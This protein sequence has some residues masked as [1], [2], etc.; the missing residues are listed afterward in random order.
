MKRGGDIIDQDVQSL[1][2]LFDV[3][4]KSVDVF[5]FSEMADLGIHEFA[6]SGVEKF[7]G[8]F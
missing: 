3:I 6:I 2:F 1:V 5:F 7:L 4:K 8:F